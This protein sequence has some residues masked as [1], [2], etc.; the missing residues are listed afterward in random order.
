MR[1]GFLAIAISLVLGATPLFATP[2]NA[3]LKIAES[4]TE[5]D[6]ADIA[7]VKAFIDAWS[8]P[9]KAA[10]YLSVKASLRMEEDKPALIGPKAF[11]DAWK[12]FFKAGVHLSVK[13]HEIFARGPVVITHRTDTVLAEGKPDQPY[14]VVGVFVVKDKKIVEWTD[15]LSK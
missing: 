3:P 4:R 9:D 5:R 10:E 11:V 14:D 12:G 7:V 8:D 15:Y 13:F 6:A 2:E 1:T